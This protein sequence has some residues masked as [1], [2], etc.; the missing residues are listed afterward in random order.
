MGYTH[1]FDA[2]PH[3]DPDRFKN[4]V[5]D[6]KKM[7]PVFQKLGIQLCHWDGDPEIKLEVT[8]KV[9]AFNGN[10]KC[11]HEQR[12]LGITWPS[13]NANGV[14][15]AYE[16]GAEVPCKT[17]VTMLNKLGYKD[18][19]IVQNGKIPSSEPDGKESLRANDSDV[20]GS[21]FAGL[22]LKTRTCGGDC[23]HESFVLNKD[24]VPEEWQKPKANGKY[25]QFCKTAYKP[26]D[27]AVNCALIIAKH[28][29][30]DQIEVRSDGTLKQWSDSMQLCQNV[31]GY[32]NDFRF[33]EEEE[34]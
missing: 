15:F 22:Q 26:Y 19:N 5:L 9:I 4:V 32:G 20:S 18:S 33:D 31:S 16:Q 24:F 28:H 14:D 34:E 2:E 3:L 27:L 13:D 11:G 21:W 29:L 25:F 1:Y 12:N 30:G 6:F 7:L 23:S 8:N 10:A 17:V